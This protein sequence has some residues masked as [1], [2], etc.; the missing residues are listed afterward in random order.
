GIP[1]LGGDDFDQA[2]AELA[3]TEEQ[4][5]ALSQGAL[6]RLQEECRQKK[7]AINPNT[8]KIAV[9]LDNVTEGAG[10]VYIPI[11]DYYE[12]CRPML[13]ET[14]RLVEDL[15]AAHGSPDLDSLYVTGG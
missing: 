2:M 8:R 14:V 6:F 15:I 13:D 4:R 1:T 7:E 12:R 3:M 9:D 10:T 11:G 5:H